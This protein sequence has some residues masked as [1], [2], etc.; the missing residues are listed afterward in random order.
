MWIICTEPHLTVASFW[1]HLFGGQIRLIERCSCTVPDERLS[2]CLVSYFWVEQTHTSLHTHTDGRFKRTYM[3][4][5]TLTPT[6][7]PMG[8]DLFVA[9]QSRGP[10]TEGWL[11]DIYHAVTS[12]PV[13]VVCVSAGIWGGHKVSLEVTLTESLTKKKNQAC[14][15]APGAGPRSNFIKLKVKKGLKNEIK[16]IRVITLVHRDVHNIWTV[17]KY[18][19]LYILRFLRHLDRDVDTFGTRWCGP[20]VICASCCC[21][22]E[23]FIYGGS[24]N[25]L[26]GYTV[27]PCL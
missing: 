18:E 17:G 2:G 1:C 19:K 8:R 20:T 4:T 23:W 6:D 12:Y 14:V 21:T 11:G 3:H 9:L 26:I 5:H 10:P 25:R 13:C 16:H 24:K 27:T 15:S 22:C 7:D